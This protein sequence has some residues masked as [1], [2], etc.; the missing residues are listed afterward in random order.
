MIIVRGG[1][2]GVLDEHPKRVAVAN[3]NGKGT[4]TLTLTP[5]QKLSDDGKRIVPLPALSDG[6]KVFLSYRSAQV[7][8]PL[9]ASSDGEK[10]PDFRDFEVVFGTAAPAPGHIRAFARPDGEASTLRI[11]FDTALDEDSVPAGSAF[12]A[13]YGELD[14]ATT[15]AGDDMVSSQHRRQRRRGDAEEGAQRRRPGEREL[16]EAGDEPAAG[17][18]RQRGAVVSPFGHVADRRAPADT[19]IGTA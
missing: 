1:R 8:H 4:V 7:A 3:A 14:D 6:E 19:E 15:V 18:G 10:V 9:R 17:R 13:R 2:G 12:T 16:H 11:T 5:K